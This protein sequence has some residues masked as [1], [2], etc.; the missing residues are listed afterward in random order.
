MAVT[1]KVPAVPT[2]KVVRSAQVMAGVCLVDGE[3]EALGGVRCRPVGG[4]EVS[5]VGAAGPCR[6]GAADSTPV[7]GL[8]VTPL[9]SVARLAEASGPGSRWRSP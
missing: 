9:G 4:G 7:V 3:R 2:V 6:R 5:V 8:S 1:V